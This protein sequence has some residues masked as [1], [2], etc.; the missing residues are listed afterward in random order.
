M[1]TTADLSDAQKLIIQSYPIE[2]TCRNDIQT[3][4]RACRAGDISLAD[5]QDELSYAFES[6]SINMQNIDT[7]AIIS[8]AILRIII[9][10]FYDQPACLNL[11]TRSGRPLILGLIR[12][13][14][15]FRD[16]QDPQRL[17]TG[18]IP[19]LDA[20]RDWQSDEAVWRELF[21]L[22]VPVL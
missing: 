6:L 18:F 15:S 1:A 11:S 20:I 21:V 10:K 19:L 14:R 3:Y 8:A 7:E 4:E 16:F 5:K 9:T 2:E 17:L 22:T 13:R 12:I